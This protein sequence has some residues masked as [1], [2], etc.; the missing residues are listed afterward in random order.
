M[1]KKLIAALTSAAMVATMV[2]ATAFAAAP[3]IAK[4]EQPAVVVA[5]EEDSANVTAFKDAVAKI[6]AKATEG[7]G[8]TDTYKAALDAAEEAYGVLTSAEKDFDDVKTSRSTLDTKQAEYTTWE[9]EVKDIIDEIDKLPNS[10]GSKTEG[11]VTA[12]TDA[13]ANGGPISTAVSH[14]NGLDVEGQKDSVT[15]IGKLHALADNKESKLTTVVGSMALYTVVNQIAKIESQQLEKVERAFNALSGTQKDMISQ[16]YLSKYQ[17]ATQTANKNE[18]LIAAY[19]KAVGDL[20]A[21]Y[22]F[23]TTIDEDNLA[24]AEALCKAAEDAYAALKNAGIEE[25]GSS[26]YQSDVVPVRNNIVKAQ[27]DAEANEE[28]KP[29]L[30]RIAALPKASS[31]TDMSSYDEVNAIYE[32]Y[33]KLS[34]AA[35]KAV[36]DSTLADDFDAVAAAVAKV[37]NAMTPEEQAARAKA[38]IAQLPSSEYKV[39]QTAR[40]EYRMATN[41]GV[42]VPSIKTP[43]NAPANYVGQAIPANVY[44]TSDELAIMSTIGNELVKAYRAEV[45]AI[46]DMIGDLR[47]AD[48]PAMTDAEFATAKSTIDQVEAAVANLSPE[49]ASD[50]YYGKMQ[51]SDSDT[52][53]VKDCVTALISARDTYLMNATA[54][55]LKT[56]MDSIVTITSDNLATQKP[57]VEALRADYDAFAEDVKNGVYGDTNKTENPFDGEYQASLNYLTAAEAQIA[58]LELGQD[59]AKVDEAIEA[60]PIL[61]ADKTYTAEELLAAQAAIATVREAYD[62]LSADEAGEVTKYAKLVEAEKAVVAASQKTIDTEAEKIGEVGL[63]LTEAQIQQYK[64]VYDLL[65]ALGKDTSA[66]TG[67]GQGYYKAAIAKLNV[68]YPNAA[69]VSEQLSKAN[70]KANAS[71]ADILA[72]REAYDALSDIEKTLVDPESVAN[73]LDVEKNGENSDKLLSK[74]TVAAIADQEY[75]GD[76]IRPTLTVTSADKKTL[77]EGTDYTVT[78]NNNVLVGTA[79]VTITGTGDYAGTITTAFDIVGISIND[80]TVTVAN[81]QTYTGSALTP[82]VTVKVDGKELTTADYDVAY[83]N[84]T[85]VGTATVTITGKGNYAGTA[86]AKFEIVKANIQ[87]ASVTGVANRY[88]TGKAR[89]QTDLRVY[90]AGKVLS[91]DNYS[92]V[93]KNNK[94]IGQASL[95]ITGKG[96]YTGTITKTFIVKPRKVASVKVTKGKKRVTVRYKKQNGARYQIYYKK[97][98]TKAKTVKTA[99]VKRTIKKLKSGKTYTIKV[100]AYKKIGSKTY[101]G[102]YSKAKK[103]RVR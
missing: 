66:I 99:A 41:A 73:L 39:N 83:S 20:K 56:R 101:Y 57:I 54:N 89:T 21:K 82:A 23:S 97:A 88:Y 34:T 77:K 87:N 42:S 30:D 70:L 48:I 1:K 98:G 64:V 22:T 91:T 43:T 32:A 58:A 35:K 26:S 45:Q 79:T 92:V 52:T 60:L 18:K 37:Y 29:V 51:M 11:N 27:K 17:K 47:A 93:Y 9:N 67:P 69:K 76:Q 61:D 15:N 81:Q 8:Y 44:F 46:I 63:T 65:S 13:Y 53:S 49:A 75:T 25:Q 50:T 14:Y 78:Y 28:A 74:A 4:S 24:E 55:G 12:Y 38:A 102:K 100:R 85:N 84:N 96:N 72:A 90:I 36:K 68:M 40:N 94:N 7:Y 80:A 10:L 86:T 95:T 33:N 59:A 3:S 62:N 2:P 31:I 103:V 5:A 19:I 16:E 6:P 71:A